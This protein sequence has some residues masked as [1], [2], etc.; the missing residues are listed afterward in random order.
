MT[1][2]VKDIV[3]IGA[4][5]AGII[6]LK[7]LLRSRKCPSDLKLNIYLIS[8]NDY[9]YFNMASPRLILE[10]ESCP[11]VLFKLQDTIDKY[12][13]NTR[14]SVTF[15]QGSVGNVDLDKRVVCLAEDDG[16]QIC[17]DNL[18]ITTGTRL[19]EPGFKLDNIQDQQYSVNGIK[20]LHKKLESA[21][22][23][24]IV[25]AGGTGVEIAGEIGDDFG[26]TKKVVLYS[27]RGMPLPRFPDPLRRKASEK[28]EKLGVEIVNND[29][30]KINEDGKS[31]TL[32]DGTIKEYSVVV[33]AHRNIP[34]TDFLPDTVLSDT[35]YIKTDK[36]LRLENYHN[37]ICMGDVL[38]MGVSSAVDLFHYQKPVLTKT[39][40]YE[41]FERKSTKLKPYQ[42]EKSV[43]FMCP[44]GRDGGVALSF[45]IRMPN[46]IVRSQRAKDYSIS[47]AR[48][49]LT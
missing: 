12:V 16:S 26:D 34:N 49:F 32:K 36:Y 24:A 14:H 8:P 28:L 48:W 2:R 35:K 15:I 10:P 42:T 13:K 47:R 31:V 45:G 19:M 25:G 4:S 39:I 22:S 3:I 9:T 43:S 20:S 46:F 11:K 5:Y 7:I 21:E 33:Q 1:G 30:V 38:D 44:I 29:K 6:A 23:I 18:L 41:I 17:Y 37:V 40:E 27:G